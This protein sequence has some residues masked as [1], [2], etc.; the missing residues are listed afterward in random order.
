MAKQKWK[1]G[2]ITNPQGGLPR[3]ILNIKW[4]VIDKYVS[5]GAKWAMN[6]LDNLDEDVH[7]LSPKER[8][9][10]K[11]KALA[12]IIRLAPQRAD[13]TSNGEQVLWPMAINI[14]NPNETNHESECIDV[15]T[16]EKTV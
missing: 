13:V 12:Q 4:E 16:N 11:L 14:V 15:S 10:A 6:V 1:K 9:D 7:Q 2:E 8:V 3:S 5:D